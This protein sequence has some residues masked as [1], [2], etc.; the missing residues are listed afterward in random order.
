MVHTLNFVLLGMVPVTK[1]CLRISD[2]TGSPESSFW[3]LDTASCWQFKENCICF[4]NLQ[5]YFY[6]LTYRMVF[7]SDKVFGFGF[8]WFFFSNQTLVKISVTK[9]MT[10]LP[11]N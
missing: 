7:Q 3:I 11:R 8:C 2:T 5:Q 1:Y 6:F 10:K 9:I 4:I